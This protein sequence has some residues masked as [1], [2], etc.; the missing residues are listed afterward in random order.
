MGVTATTGG[1]V[2]AVTRTKFVF[3]GGGGGG[4][5]VVTTGLTGL[6]VVWA[7]DAFGWGLVRAV[8]GVLVFAGVFA[9]V[10]VATTAGEVV[11]LGGV[12]TGF[13]GVTTGAT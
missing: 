13:A 4:L 7:M 3:T 9:G 2:G 12:V 11:V 10:T 8:V 6:L 5:V 1:L